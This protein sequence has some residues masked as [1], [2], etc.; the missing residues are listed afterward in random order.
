MRGVAS[1]AIYVIMKKLCEL[2][3]NFILLTRS[4]NIQ[5]GCLKALASI[6]WKH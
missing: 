4:L 3:G 5:E 6:I 2:Q 1:S